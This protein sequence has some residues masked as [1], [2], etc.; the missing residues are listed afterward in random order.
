MKTAISIPD[1]IFK[2]AEILADRLKISRSEL[3]SKAILEFLQDHS[4]DPVTEKLNEIYAK[5]S[6]QPDPVF[7]TMREKLFRKEKW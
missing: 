4:V 6:S 2:K 3:Y 1:P 7:K 5:E